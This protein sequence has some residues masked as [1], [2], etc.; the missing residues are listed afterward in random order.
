MEMTNKPSSFKK[1][2]PFLKNRVSNNIHRKEILHMN[3]LATDVIEALAIKQEIAEVFLRHLETAINQLLKYELTAFLK[4]EPNA[5][6]GF[7]SGNFPERILR[8]HLKTEYVELQLAI[9]RD[10]N[11]GFQQETLAPYQRS[12]DT[13]E[14]FVIHLYEKGITTEE[15]ADLMERMYGHH[16]YRQTVSNFTQLVAGLS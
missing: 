6:E 14:Q 12:N 4:Y 5:R 10:L 3:Y 1:G 13:L 15:I 2:R 9:P 8:S 7:H 11:S 16:Y